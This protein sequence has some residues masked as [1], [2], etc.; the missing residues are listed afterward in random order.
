MMWFC[1]RLLQLRVSTVITV[2]LCLITVIQFF[3]AYGKYN[4]SHLPAEVIE[5]Q[6]F[7]QIT[8]KLPLSKS[9]PDCKYDQI[10]SN[11]ESLNPWDIPKKFDSFNANGVMNGTYMPEHCNPMF[12][13]AILVTYRN[14][15]KQL[16]IFLPYMH[17]F[18]RKQNLHYK[19]YLIE[20]QD[21][22]PWNKGVLYNIGA[23][24][25]ISDKFPCLIL[26]DV[27]LLPLDA[28]N[29]YACTNDPRHMSSSIDKFRYVL[30]YDYLV[31]GALAIKSDHFVAF[32]GFSNRFEG[33]GGEDDDFAHRLAS[34]KLDVVRFPRE[35][36]RYTMMVHRQE[37]KNSARHSIM[38]QNKARAAADGLSS[39]PY[40]DTRLKNH[41]L[42]TLIGAKL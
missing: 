32:N 2:I 1:D 33:W 20:Q 34:H 31:G 5:T 15:Q 21:E 40:H 3:A 14:R 29:L 24:Q 28:S 11:K 18:L 19:I 12:S 36:S 6:L 10:L 39:L 16:D 38:G 7:K 42:F 30:T 22:K 8:P 17:D 23:K 27:D 4:Y 26:H 25:A 13:V 41:R 35:M 37:S 9:K